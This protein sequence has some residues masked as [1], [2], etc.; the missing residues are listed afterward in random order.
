MALKETQQILETIKRSSRPL[1]CVPRAGGADGY[2]AAI[3]L[4]RV[5]EK[6]DKNAD[7]VAAD[8][9]TPKNLH[10]LQKHERIQPRLENLRRFV[11]E[12][13][14]SKTKVDELTY[15]MKDEKLL[16]HLAPKTGSWESK[17]VTLSASGYRYD[18]IICLGSAD[19]ESCAHLYADHPD[20][21]YRTPII[22]VDHRAENEHYGHI[23]VVDLTA[24]AT[25]EVC[26]DLVEAIEPGLL[27]EDVAT[28]FLTGMIAKT[29]SFKTREVTP[30]T[31]QTASKLVARGAKRELIVHHLY[32]TRS[33]PTL[34]LWGRALARLKSDAGAHVVWTLLSKQDFL[35]AGAEEM[36]LPDVVDE[37]IASSPDAKIVALLYETDDRGI[38]GILRAE[39]PFDILALAAPLK[40]NGTRE[41]ARVAFPGKTIVQAERETLACLTGKT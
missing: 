24:V 37:L 39:R 14:A 13:D 35:H 36:D 2:A 22:N 17:D 7:V 30:K 12:L 41:E 26:H 34:R 20:F 18:L 11:I 29:R 10:F 40:P 6:L 21:F 33:V 9:T 38:V 19:L 1:I 5:L 27:D 3:G 25:S 28:A 16:I 31:L 23:N 15:E 32:R 4:A 8:G